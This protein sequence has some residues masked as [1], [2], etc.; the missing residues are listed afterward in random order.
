[1]NFDR[2]GRS[3][4][5]CQD[6][7]LTK[8]K[9]KGPLESIPQ[10]PAA[11]VVVVVVFSAVVAIVG[12]FVVEEIGMVAVAV[13]EYSYRRWNFG[14]WESRGCLGNRLRQ[15]RRENT[16]H[17]YENLCI[18]THNKTKEKCIFWYWSTDRPVLGSAILNLLSIF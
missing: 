6:S 14:F 10:R 3:E 16:V 18:R 8:M 17:K 1:M 5:P 11:D 4:I 9:R 7:G 2:P 15:S 12:V 13:G